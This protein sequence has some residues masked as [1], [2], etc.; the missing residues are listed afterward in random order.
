MKY[1]HLI[2][3]KNK[4]NNEIYVCHFGYHKVNASG[5]FGPSQRGY[6]LFHFIKK[7]KGVYRVGGKTFTLGKNQGF[8]IKPKEEVYY[9]ADEKEPWE[10]EFIAFNGI[11]AEALVNSVSWEDGYIITPENCSEIIKIMHSI[12]KISNREVNQTG[13]GYRLM[14]GLYLLFAELVK[15]NEHYVYV[16]QDEK[17]IILKKAI[18]YISDHYEEEIGVEDIARHVSI[19]RTNLFRLFKKELNLSVLQYIQNFR[20]DKAANLLCNTTLSVYEVGCR[21]GMP[22][23]SYFC[24]QFKKF[25]KHTPKNFRKHFSS[26]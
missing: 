13:G 12:V 9:C 25:F 15:Q 24:K 14:G 22:D 1:A 18:D 4:L 21:V 11:S 7:G 2:F 16:E 23:N 10:Y 19:H 17:K 3:P 8:I 5:A 6:Y 26:K 20:M